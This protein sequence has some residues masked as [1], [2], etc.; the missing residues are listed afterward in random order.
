MTT[1]NVLTE[2]LRRR[3]YEPVPLNRSVVGQFEVEATVDG[4][5]VLMLIDTG[6]SCSVLDGKSALEIGLEMQQCAEPG[7]KAVGAG[8]AVPVSMVKVDELSVRSTSM[9]SLSMP[10]V[11]LDHCNAALEDKG[12]RRVGGV[13]GADFLSE[14]SAIIE[15][16]NSTLFLKG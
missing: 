4:H 1:D 13:L 11:N 5:E 9:G 16:A 8:G 7:K 12:A 14:K 10:V 6:A 15:Y 2:F 3:G